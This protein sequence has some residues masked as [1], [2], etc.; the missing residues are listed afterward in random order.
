MQ[1]FVAICF[2]FLYN[3][4]LS[5]PHNYRFIQFMKF[6][7]GGTNELLNDQSHMHPNKLIAR[8]ARNA[9]KQAIKMAVNNLQRPLCDK[10]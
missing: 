1:Y 7:R 9:E 2:P 10:S 8:S 6:C 4:D 3:L 5:L